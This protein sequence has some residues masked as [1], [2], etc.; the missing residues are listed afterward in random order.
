MNRTKI[1]LYLDG[2]FFGFVLSFIDRGYS[3]LRD[4]V[5]KHQVVEI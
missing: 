4:F 5:L 2:Y 3:A 1:K